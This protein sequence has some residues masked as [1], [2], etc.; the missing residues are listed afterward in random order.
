MKV[1]TWKPARDVIAGTTLKDKNQKEDNNLALH[2]GGNLS[3]VIEN[4]KQ[5]CEDLK[6][7]LSQCVFLQ[8]THSD[9]IYQATLLDAGK[10]TLV[11]EDGIG[12]H[13]AIYTKEKNLLIGVFHADCVPI[14]LYDPMHDIIA[15]VHSGWQG[16]VK[17]IL[18]KTIAVLVEKEGVD[19][20]QLHAYIGPAIAF[21]SFEVGEEVV[22][23][24]EAMSFNTSA[25]IKRDG[26]GKAFVD[27]Q[28]LNLQMLLNYGVSSEHITV[29]KSDTFTP[30]DALF[31]YRRD[32]T[33]GRHLTFILQ[34]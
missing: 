18:R 1:L 6:I 29:N 11:Y 12:D 21:H 16:T 9:H 33:C 20:A 31:S 30:N 3:Y 28:G 22:E 14:L 34:K 8:Q 19:P 15:A 23:K 5:L 24:V 32:H 27:N 7:D 25:F 2:T 26:S 10:G 4:R 17:E 13:D